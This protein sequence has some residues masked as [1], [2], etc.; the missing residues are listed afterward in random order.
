[1]T[2]ATPQIASS[3]PTESSTSGIK[4]ATPD[5]IVQSEATPIDALSQI[6][7]ESVAGHEIINIA[8][9]TLINGI[10][11]SYSLI[12]NLSEL[13][14]RYNPLNIFTLPETIDKYFKNF[15][16]RLDIHVPEEG[17]GPEKQRVWIAET[18]LAFAKKGDI[19][20]DVTNMEKNEVVDVQILNSGSLLSDTIYTEAS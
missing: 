2:E 9:S 12:G 19:I 15:A 20:I 17:S 14:R 7:F 18:D 10:N 4:I 5:L 13:Q 6:Y 3:T 16:I 11:V 1:M 8:R